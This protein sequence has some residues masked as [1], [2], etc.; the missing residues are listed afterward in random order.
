MLHPKEN[1]PAT[2]TNTVNISNILYCNFYWSHGWWFQ[3]LVYTCILVSEC[4]CVL[5]I[6]NAHN[7][8][9]LI[10]THTH[11]ETQR[12]QPRDYVHGKQVIF[13][14]FFACHFG[15]QNVPQMKIYCFYFYY[16][17]ILFIFA[18]DHLTAAANRNRQN[19]IW[20]TVCACT[21]R[22][23]SRKYHRKLSRR[24]Y[25]IKYINIFLHY[26]TLLYFDCGSGGGGGGER[27]VCVCMSMYRARTCV[28]L[29]E[30]AT[31][32]NTWHF[33]FAFCAFNHF[34]SFRPPDYL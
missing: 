13:C 24:V 4:V 19:K 12:Q 30:R 31:R 17:I 23:Q 33:S 6:A 14:T 1:A 5:S 21:R 2:H 8:P 18:V 10:I 29:L 25:N 16:I 3:Y 9:F 32:I 26:F 28:C 15:A 27:C 22:S 7:F 34:N 11:T 20:L